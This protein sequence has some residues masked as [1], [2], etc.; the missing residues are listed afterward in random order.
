MLLCAEPW[1]VRRSLGNISVD[2]C[3]LKGVPR[4]GLL[5]GCQP[6]SLSITTIVALASCQA[7]TKV[8]QW[9]S[10]YSCAVR[11]LLVRYSVRS[12]ESSGPT[13]LWVFSLV[14]APRLWTDVDVMLQKGRISNHFQPGNTRD[15]DN[16]SAWLGMA[17]LQVM[18]GV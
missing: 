7:Q 5:R 6:L 8:L 14:G 9:Q 16:S 17:F 3:R 2:C 1:R 4:A 10:V 12:P 11:K 13:E 18:G 15:A